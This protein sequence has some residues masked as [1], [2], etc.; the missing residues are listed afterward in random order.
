MLKGLHH[1]GIAVTALDEAVRVWENATGGHCVHREVVET[2]GVE[3]AVIEIG[4]LRV[5]LLYEIHRRPAD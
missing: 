1:I 3:V 2:Q 5:E 4:E